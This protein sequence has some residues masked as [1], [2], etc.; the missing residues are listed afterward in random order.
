MFFIYRK[1]KCRHIL[2]LVA[3]NLYKKCDTVLCDTTF[4]SGSN[5]NY[6]SLVFMFFFLPKKLML[7]FSS[8]L[9]FFRPKI[10]RFSSP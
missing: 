3:V 1:N 7:R 6:F 5:K 9:K 4:G 10:K 8:F 2:R